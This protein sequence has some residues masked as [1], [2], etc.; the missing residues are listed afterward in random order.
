MHLT[1]DHI[2]KVLCLYQTGERIRIQKIDQ[3][4]VYYEREYGSHYVAHPHTADA[5]IEPD[6]ERCATFERNYK[7]GYVLV[8]AE[9]KA[10]RMIHGGESTPEMV[11]EGQHMLEVIHGQ[12]KYLMDTIDHLNATERPHPELVSAFLSQLYELGN[13]SH[14][15]FFGHRVESISSHTAAFR[16]DGRA[17][18]YDTALDHLCEQ[19]LQPRSKSSLDDII[20]KADNR[21]QKNPFTIEPKAITEH[22]L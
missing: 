10:Q 9:L 22:E 17:M 16:V 15:T 11:A 5:F 8:S 2:G 13:G 19:A 7:L 6:A 14:D 1:Q 20:H 12:Q 3:S 18:D 4:Y 21:R